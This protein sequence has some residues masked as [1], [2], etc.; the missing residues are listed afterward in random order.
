MASQQDIHAAGAE[1]RPPM[2]S[3]GGYSQWASHMMPYLKSKPNGK[4]LVNS[5]LEGPFK[6]R[7]VLDP[8]DPNG[9]NPVQPYYRDQTEAEYTEEDKL[10][11]AADDQ[12]FHLV[13]LGLP[14]ITYATVD[15]EVSAHAVWER[16][17]RL[18]YGTDIGKQEMET[19]LLKELHKFTSIL[20]ESIESTII[21]STKNLHE[22]NY[23]QLYDF[24]KQNQAEANEV[25]AE[26][27]AKKHDPLA[28][29][30]NAP[31]P[32]S[33]NTP[34]QPSSSS[35]HN[36]MQP[37]Y[38]PQ[39]TPVYQQQFYPQQQ[40]VI[41]QQQYP[42]FQEPEF[43]DNDESTAALTQA[44]AYLSKAQIAQPSFNIGQGGPMVG[45]IGN[46][47]GYAT[48]FQMG[49]QNMQNQ[50]GQ[51]A[52]NQ[53]GQYAGNQ[54]VGNQRLQNV[55][56]QTVGNQIGNIAAPFVRNY[57]N[58]NQG[59]PVKC[60]NCQGVG[61][62][63][64][65]CPTKPR[66]TDTA[67]L[68]KALLLAQ[69]Q[70]AGFQLNAEE[71][72]FMALM[73]DME[74]QEDIDANYIF[75]AN[76]QE[77]K[78]DTD[79]DTPPV[80]DTNAIS[81]VPLFNTCNNNAIFDMSPHEEQHSETSAPT[82]YIYMDTPSS[83]NIDSATPDMNHSGGP[84]SQHAENDEETRALFDSLL[85]NCSIEIEKVK[86]VNRE[87]KAANEKLTAELE[88][89]KE[90]QKSFQIDLRR[91]SDFECGYKKLL[92]KYRELQNKF[93]TLQ[94]SSTKTINSLKQEISD[95]TNQLSK[96]KT[97]YTNLE[98]G[99]DELKK[100][101]AKKEDKLLDEIIE[102]EHMIA[103]L[104]N[105]LIKTGHSSQTIHMI[106]SQ[107]DPIYYTKH[108][109]ALGNKTPCN[110]KKAQEEHNVLYNGNVIHTKHDP[111]I[112]R[113]YVETIELAEDS[114]IK[115]KQKSPDQ[116]SIDY[117]KINKLSGITFVPQK[118]TSA[119]SKSSV[120]SKQNWATSNNLESKMRLT[121][122]NWN[123]TV[124]LQLKK[125]LESEFAPQINNINARVNHFEKAFL[126]ETVDFIKDHKSLIKKA[127]ESIVQINV[128]ENL[129]DSL[130]E[131]VL[132][133]D[134]MSTILQTHFVKEH[135]RLQSENSAIVP[136]YENALLK[137][138]K[139]NVSYFKQLD[140]KS[141]E[142]KYDKLS[143]EHAFKNM[144][145][146]NDLLRAQLESQK[147]KGVETKFAKPGLRRN[148]MLQNRIIINI[149]KEVEKAVV[150]KPKV[151]APGLYRISTT[152]ASVSTSKPYGTNDMSL[153]NNP[154]EPRKAETTSNDK[155]VNPNVC[156]LPS[157]GLES[158]S[159]SSRLQPRSNTRNNRVSPVSKSR[160][161]N[162]IEEVEEHPR[163]LPL[164]NKR[165]ISS[166]CN[167]KST[168]LNACNDSVCLMCNKSLF[169]DVH[170]DCVSR[171]LNY[172]PEHK[173]VP[174]R[175]SANPVGSLVASPRSPCRNK[176]PR[177]WK[178][179]GKKFSVLK[180]RGKIIA[181]R[182]EPVETFY[183]CDTDFTSNPKEPK[184]KRF[185]KTS[186]SVLCRLSKY[187]MTGN[188]KLLINFVWKFLGT[189]RFGNDHAAAILG[190]GDIHFGNYL[191]T[192]VYYVEG[193][194]H[195]LFSVGQF[196]DADLEVAFRRNTCF[197][198]NLE[199]DDL[200]T[201]NR[202][203]NLYAIDI[204]QMA[205]SSP[206]CLMTRASDT[207][208]WLWHRRLSHLNFDTIN[209]LAKDNIVNGLPKFKYTKEHLCPSC[210]Q[211][212]GI[213]HQTSVFRTPQQNGVVERRNRTLVEATCTMLIYSS[214]PLFLWAD[215]VATA[216][217]T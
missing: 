111:P 1:N 215:A 182:V 96:Q 171:Y 203:T 13:V 151:I 197:V 15:S 194:G 164:C 60:F 208:S 177:T 142:C 16:I 26:L 136:K 46:H 34:H 184:S 137:L 141:E 113:D 47:Q 102:S 7:Q 207:K 33:V 199:G 185:P 69:K 64:R 30:A 154:K 195:N 65:N 112:V 156:A 36:Y 70:D 205:S 193:L 84:V 37:P 174:K 133:N 147:G 10:Q 202:G 206:I 106:T 24:L 91:E 217:F 196:F 144:K 109:M 63:A 89:Y 157:T 180:G 150:E 103:K 21:G 201:G 160:C 190:Y 123:S 127:N 179:T 192:R 19:Q 11:I 5:V 62:I 212:V 14:E 134:I 163:T 76:L 45:V 88:R 2:L 166:E 176:M 204:N 168:D 129:N 31:A 54:F 122:K 12:A 126:T 9:T 68:K 4:L 170:D 149:E 95:L 92:F 99:R 181:V 108:K 161:M 101:F 131:A 42:Q 188:L 74:E 44:L 120:I 97:T 152:T 139:E 115:M 8:G 165:H 143:Y 132:S 67:Y 135:E 29:I 80:Y 128:L 155:N 140:R 175:P 189:I 90:N 82:Y 98:K 110:L 55:G 87:V 145:E 216:C 94:I 17:K 35:T 20:G 32:L 173:S 183:E 25:R 43:T 93:D 56:N 187:H 39:P 59:N 214:A 200:L 57:G 167:V 211:D 61:H 52:G 73:D 130:L 23:D 169:D 148:K 81:E 213:T 100:V 66:K 119:F 178:P 118:Q 77:A 85:N 158:T 138:E 198:R 48:G 40:Y 159:R 125:I 191:I 153:H 209:K 83:S 117:N 58:V 27:L 49:N 22:V 172:M 162:K 53:M 116:K 107:T 18:M 75:M 3:K 146:Q 71:N 51:Y 38:I 78:Y 124:H 121:E 86:K 41:P 50:L 210:E 104:E 72:D 28:L 186:S 79:S 6:L 114:Q 105:L